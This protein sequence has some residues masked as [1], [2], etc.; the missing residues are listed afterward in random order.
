M[1]SVPAN[2]RQ[3]VKSSVW[4]GDDGERYYIPAGAQYVF[5]NASCTQHSNYVGI[6]AER[7]GAQLVC[8]VAKTFG[9]PT[10][11]NSTRIDGLTNGT[12]HTS[13]LTRSSSCRSTV[14]RESVLDSRYVG[15]LEPPRAES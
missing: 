3:A 12:R 10:R 7:H 5:F 1:P 14:G 9:V 15:P 4:I 2:I 6:L 8:T 11:L 13:C